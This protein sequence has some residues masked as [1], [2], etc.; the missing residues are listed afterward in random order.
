LLRIFPC[1][2]CA[3][4]LLTPYKEKKT[5]TKHWML[6]YGPT[7]L[8]MQSFFLLLVVVLLF[9]AV[10]RERPLLVLPYVFV[11]SFA[12]FLWFILTIVATVFTVASAMGLI[13]IA[14]IGALFDLW[15]TLVI[16]SAFFDIRGI[17][18]QL[19]DK[20]TRWA[21]ELE[22]DQV[23]PEPVIVSVESLIIPS[24][25]VP[26]KR[27][28]SALSPTPI[29]IEPR[30]RAQSLA[31]MTQQ[32]AEFRDLPFEHPRR[33]ARIEKKDKKKKLDASPAP[34]TSKVVL[35]RPKFVV[36]EKEA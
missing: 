29:T 33:S 34:G 14:G 6:V 11:Q 30:L 28:K 20:G 13:I 25:E 32:R 36:V 1:V 35:L 15:C 12:I 8:F 16:V 18:T 21:E 5:E 23:I 4:I 24:I 7:V 26:K 9:T 10:F 2:V 27:K 19:V 22:V 3:I 17:R 31:L